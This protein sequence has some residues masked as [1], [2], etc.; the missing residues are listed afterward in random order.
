M[1][2]NDKPMT[3]DEAREIFQAAI[4]KEPNPDKRAELELLREYFMNPAF[5]QAMT[6]FIF[7]VVMK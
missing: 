4:D 1:D 3:T 7:D 2:T 5:R 6:D